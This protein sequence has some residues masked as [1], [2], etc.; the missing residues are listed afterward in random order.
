MTSLSERHRPYALLAELTY[1]CPLHCPYCSNPSHYNTQSHVLTTCEWQRILREAS[2]LGVLHALFSGG[3]PLLRDDLETLISTAREC[4]MYIN[5]ITSA[6]GLSR[7][8]GLA[9]KE[10]GLD[11]IQISFQSDKQP[12]NDSIA[13]ARVFELKKAAAELVRS[14]EL[15]LTMNVVLHRNNIS[16][17]ESI[18][19]LA[20]EL[21]AE[22]LELA[23]VQ[24]Y[25]WAFRNKENLLPSLSQINSAGAIAAAAAARLR[26]RMD[27]LWIRPDYYDDRP[28]PCMNGW[29]RQY[30]TVNPV[31][32]VLPC[33]TAG[34][35]P[36]LRFANVRDHSLEWIWNDSDAFNKFR[37]TDWMQQPCRDCEFRTVDFGGCRCQAALL[38][39][40]AAHTDPACSLS[41][42]RDILLELLS[43]AQ[44]AN[45]DPSV[46]HSNANPN[47]IYRQNPTT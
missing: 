18:I 20:E 36:S 41:P 11:S 30:M 43:G 23:N 15:P 28:K 3:E 31:G 9:F 34:D 8:R 19:A 37:G 21:G 14:L 39:G 10:A 2:D 25:G 24:F 46:E 42:H 27:V 35:I 4:G 16:R 47:L 44:D 22:R 33:P 5:L 13:G 29:G 17:I 6:V 40:D 38:T 26:G 1:S 12:L 32:D 45:F 7:E